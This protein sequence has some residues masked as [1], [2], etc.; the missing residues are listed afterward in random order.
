VSDKKAGADN[1]PP[2]PSAFKKF[3]AKI[4]LS[5]LQKNNFSFFFRGKKKNLQIQATLPSIL[6]STREGRVRSVIATSF[7]QPIEDTNKISFSQ[8]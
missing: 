3:V 5:L 6:F 4:Q 8:K 1:Y 2:P 7:S